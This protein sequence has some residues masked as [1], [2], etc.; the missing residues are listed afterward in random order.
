MRLPLALAA[1][2]VTAAL[3]CA[4]VSLA[5]QRPAR[6]ERQLARS[7]SLQELRA[8]DRQVDS[9]VRA[10]R[11]RVRRVSEDTLLAGREHERFDQFHRGVRV[12]GG[13]LTR[14]LRSGRPCPCS[15]RCTATS[16]PT[17]RRR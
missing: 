10:G 13:D 4:A 14:Q 5:A 8:A 17:R 7:A 2:A 16:R 15:G 3:A 1:A 9:L 6:F 12:W 11:L